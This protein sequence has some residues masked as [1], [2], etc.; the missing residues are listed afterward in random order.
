MKTAQRAQTTAIA[1]LLARCKMNE[2]EQDVAQKGLPAV[3]ADGEDGCCDDGEVTGYR[4]L[5]RIERIVLPDLSQLGRGLGKDGKAAQGP[6]GQ[7]PAAPEASGAAPGTPA[8][9]PTPSGS[10]NPSTLN[11]ATLLSGGGL[12]AGKGGG[13]A[14]AQ[15]AMSYALPIL[16]PVIEEQVRR[17]SVDVQWREGK[18]PRNLKVT[19]FLVAEP[20]VLPTG[21]NPTGATGGATGAAASSS[22]GSQTAGGS[23]RR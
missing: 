23:V 8:P 17:A 5:W 14:L 12:S 1:T 2:L 11:P 4:C 15:M 21:A 9:L 16:K 13:D 19:Q 22:T 10:L 18:R 7:A 3:S 6:K 20:A